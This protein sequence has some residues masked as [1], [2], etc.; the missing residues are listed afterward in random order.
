MPKGASVGNLAYWMH[1]GIDHSPELY[2]HNVVINCH[3]SPGFLHIGGSGL[4]FG[5]GEEAALRS[6]RSKGAIGRIIIVACQVAA[7]G[8]ASKR[9]GKA[10]CTNIAQETGAFVLAADALQSVDF[11]YENFSHPFGTIDDFEGTVYE[12]NPAGGH[13]VWAGQES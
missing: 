4:G 10:F 1:W 2:L 9:L 13:E 12:F 6:L 5:E 7:E 11:W 3:G 8:E